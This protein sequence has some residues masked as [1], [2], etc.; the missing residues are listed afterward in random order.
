MSVEFIAASSEYLTCGSDASVDDIAVKT[1]VAWICPDDVSADQNILTKGK[2]GTNTGWAFLCY[3]Q[4]GTSDYVLR[5]TEGWADAFGGWST[6]N[7]FSYGT[8]YHVAVVYDSG[9]TANNPVFYVSG[10]VEANTESNTPAGAHGS[11]AATTL[12]VGAHADLSA[13]F[14]DG[15]IEDIRLFNR[16]LSTEEITGLAAGYRGPVGG[17]IM[18]LSLCEARG[19][20]GGFEAASLA[21]GTNLCP[22]L[23]TNTNDG[24]P[25]NTPTGRASK[26]PRYGVAV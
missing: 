12:L 3:D 4:A 16:A 7:T 13:A 17:E 19:V 25:T 15:K 20:S 14:F 2:A 26:V 11:D 10:A 8:L 18:W 24:D 22:D 5:L 9:A 23:S 1:I 21:N 6:D